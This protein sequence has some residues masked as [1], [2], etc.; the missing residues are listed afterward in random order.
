MTTATA[1]THV[2]ADA[3]GGWQPAPL[4]GTLLAMAKIGIQESYPEG[5]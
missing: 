5:Q 3:T 4:T 1:I 2:N